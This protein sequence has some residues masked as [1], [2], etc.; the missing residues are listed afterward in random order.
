MFCWGDGRTVFNSSLFL[1][2]YLYLFDAFILIIRLNYL[3]DNSVIFTL[4]FTNLCTCISV[5][6]NANTLKYIR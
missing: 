6:I 3:R 1:Y 4:F 2:I 5:N